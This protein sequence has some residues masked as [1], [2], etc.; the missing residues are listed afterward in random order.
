MYHEEFEDLKFTGNKGRDAFIEQVL[1]VVDF[2]SDSEKKEIS[3]LL[4]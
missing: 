1:N 4:D 3:K 2:V